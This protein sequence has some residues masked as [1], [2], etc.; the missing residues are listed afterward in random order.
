[1]NKF[2]AVVLIDCWD[3]NQETGEFYWLLDTFYRNQLVPY[4][5][6]Q[7]FDY[8]VYVNQEPHNNTID[9][10]LKKQI[11]NKQGSYP[12]NFEI[13]NMYDFVTLPIWSS[14]RIK[15]N[16]DI[17]FGGRAWGAC[18]HF[19]SLNLQKFLCEPFDV[20][21][22]PEIVTNEGDMT[23]HD[24]IFLEDPLIEFEK[25]YRGKDK[26]FKFKCT[27]P[28]YAFNGSPNEE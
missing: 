22:A 8:V 28:N 27:R 13:R 4:L 6:T 23:F 2:D 10:G 12:Q 7:D 20:Y 16:A 5:S 11:K 24:E 14:E 25:V 19:G 15:G 18:I 3:K 17:L 1:M 9:K 21:V 26:F